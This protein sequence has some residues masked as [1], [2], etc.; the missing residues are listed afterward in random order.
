MSLA[1]SPGNGT[2]IEATLP[3]A[4]APAADTHSSVVDDT[5]SNA[6]AT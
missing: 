1:S 4:T 5:H 3:L 6:T 2:L